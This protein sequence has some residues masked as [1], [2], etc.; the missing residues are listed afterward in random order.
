MSV[1]SNNLGMTVE[2]ENVDLLA[3]AILK[4]YSDRLKPNTFG[5]NAA[6]YAKNNLG[7]NMILIQFEI[8]LESVIRKNIRQ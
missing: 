2:P 1:S 4:L 3:N 7:M 6:A 5:R 8:A